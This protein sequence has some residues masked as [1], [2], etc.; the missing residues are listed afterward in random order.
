M[1]EVIARIVK[2]TRERAKL[3]LDDVSRESG[4]AVDA[5]ASLERG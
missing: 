2:A 3:S 4:V 5:I 1:L